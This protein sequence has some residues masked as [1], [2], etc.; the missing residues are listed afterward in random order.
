MQQLTPRRPY[1]FKA[2]Y[3]WILDNELTP[4]I[5]VDCDY[6]QVDVPFEFANDGKIVLNLAPQAIGNFE[7]TNDYLCFHARF[8]GSP[9]QVYVPM[10]A[11]LAIYTREDGQGLGF[12]PETQYD[13]QKQAW[14]NKENHPSNPSATP[15]AK[16][17]KPTFTVVK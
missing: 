5:L 11:I 10:G 9:R 3:D 14:S 15:E 4:H 6:P 2:L 13:K 1:L 8:S 12:E 7:L 16:K 17:G